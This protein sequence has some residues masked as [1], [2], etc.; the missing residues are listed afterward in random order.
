MTAQEILYRLLSANDLHLKE[1]NGWIVVD[2]QM[3]G[4]C[5][6]TQDYI[7]EGE[8]ASIRLNIG[9]AVEPE[10]IIWESFLGHGNDEVSATQNAFEQFVKN[11][12]YVFLAAFWEVENLEYVGVEEWE[13]N[14]EKWKVIIGNFVCKGEFDTPQELFDTIEDVASNLQLTKNYH[15]IRTFYANVNQ[16]EKIVE[17]QLDNQVWEDGKREL[18]TV[19][20]KESED[21]YSLRNFILLQKRRHK[22]N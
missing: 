9:V 22:T 19:N 15:W 21:F 3:P 14:D 17:S 20:W 2:E 16:E 8:K 1:Y 10:R 7:Q 6:L 12:F 13:I 5:A 11:S 4:I 18:Q